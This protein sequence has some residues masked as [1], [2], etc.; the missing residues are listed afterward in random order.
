MLLAILVVLV[1]VYLLASSLATSAE[2]AAA[3]VRSGTVEIPPPSDAVDDWPVIGHQA[4][5]I[6][7]QAS[8]DL[9]AVTDDYQ[10]QLKAFGLAVLAKIAAAGVGLLLFM[11]A[12]ILAGV[13]MAYGENGHRAAVA[14]FERIFGVAAAITSPICAPRTIRAVAQG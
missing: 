14:S 12:L 3:A 4:H 1:P 9:G 11:V 10:P 8:T 7:E 2:H 6:W 5:D 13:F